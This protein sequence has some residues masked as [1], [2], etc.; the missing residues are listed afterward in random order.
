MFPLDFKLR[1]SSRI[2]IL[3]QITIIG[4]AIFLSL[5]CAQV[6]AS[7]LLLRPESREH[8]TDYD[9]SAWWMGRHLQN[10]AKAKSGDIQIVFLGDSITDQWLKEGKTSWD[11]YFS[12]TKTVNFGISGDCVRHLLW[13]VQNGELDGFKASSIILLIGT[14]D[15]HE[16]TPANTIAQ[17]ILQLV[18]SIKLKQPQAT[19]ILMGLLPRFP[20]EDAKVCDQV[21]EI[22]ASQYQAHGVQ[23]LNLSRKFKTSFDLPNIEL[24]SDEVHLNEKGY[25]LWADALSPYLVEV[26]KR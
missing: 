17:G 8:D 15:V 19:I 11:Q 22:L 2:R 7:E 25:A 9:L 6:H 21:N 3:F 1:M 16:N 18:D 23:W 20:V 14:N 5:F 4:L 12:K 24:L 26:A 13:R 10:I